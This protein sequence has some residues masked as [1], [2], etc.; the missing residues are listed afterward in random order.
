VNEQTSVLYFR[1]NL[2][3]ALRE[4]YVGFRRDI[5]TRLWHSD[6]GL[7]AASQQSAYIQL[8][9]AMMQ[10]VRGAERLLQRQG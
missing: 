8:S 6:A 2:T 3:G 4:E 1:S 10:A 9:A 5:T 7:I